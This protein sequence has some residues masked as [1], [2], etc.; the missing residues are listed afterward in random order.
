M[1]NPVPCYLGHSHVFFVFA[2]TV[3]YEIVLALWFA[4]LQRFVLAPPSRAS[5]EDDMRHRV[6]ALRFAPPVGVNGLADG[7]GWVCF[8][9]NKPCYSWRTIGCCN[10]IDDSYLLDRAKSRYM[11]H[12]GSWCL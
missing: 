10:L 6:R 1:H 4:H 2:T 3:I 5:E 12:R 9:I 8:N 11:I 7:H